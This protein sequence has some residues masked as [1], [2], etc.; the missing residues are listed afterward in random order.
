[1]NMSDPAFPDGPAFRWRAADIGMTGLSRCSAASAPYL[2]DDM[3]RIFTPHPLRPPTRSVCSASVKGGSHLSPGRRSI[4]FGGLT[5]PPFV[6][7]V[8]LAALLILGACT[9]TGSTESTTTSSTDPVSTTGEPSPTTTST[10]LTN[11][12]LPPEQDVIAAWSAY[13]N[14]WVNVRAS[15]DLDRGPLEAVASPAVVDGALTLFERQRSSG[16]GPVHTEV[17]LHAAVTA[18]VGDWATV[19]DCVLLAPSFTDAVGVWYEADL[20][21]SDEGWIVDTVRIPR[22]GGCVPKAM[23]EGAIAGYEAFY[24]GW[25]DFWDP[26]NPE[27]PLIDQVLAEPQLGLVVALLSDHEARG[28]ALR[29]RP[30]LHPEVIEVRSPT[31][32][33]ILSCLEPS[34]EYGL[35]D[36]DTGERLDDVPA[37]RDGQKNLESAVMILEDGRWKV[38]DLQGQVDFACDF[39][40]T[41]RGLPS[42]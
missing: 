32:V 12:T 24:A 28:A 2:F 16:L 37:V 1:M 41:D 14:A 15:D 10:S 40:P 13:W 42:V 11:T 20:V 33:V 36:I 18:A 31:E 19:E 7:G 27:S 39:A 38:S 3:T 23:A 30:S 17:A 6:V 29:G 21:R 9:L 22:A 5:R 35:Y 34:P 4:G 8:A 26:A 25:T